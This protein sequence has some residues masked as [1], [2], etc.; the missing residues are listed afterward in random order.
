MRAVGEDLVTRQGQV[1]P[2]SRSMYESSLHHKDHWWR[3]DLKNLDKVRNA[4]DSDADL[5]VKKYGSTEANARSARFNVALPRSPQHQKYAWHNR[6]TGSGPLD[7]QSTPDVTPFAS[8]KLEPAS[9]VSPYAD[10][11]HEDSLTRLTLCQQGAHGGLRF[12]KHTLM[13]WFREMDT[14]DTGIISRRQVV[15]HLRH[16]PEFHMAV[17]GNLEEGDPSEEA[18]VIGSLLQ[19]VEG[20]A[21]GHLEW[22]DFVKFFRGC[23]LLETFEL[24][25]ELAGDGYLVSFVE[26]PQLRNKEASDN[27]HY[28]EALAMEIRHHA[29]PHQE[30]RYRHNRHMGTPVEEGTESCRRSSVQR[31]SLP[32]F[33]EC[34]GHFSLAPVGE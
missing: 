33:E 25:R 16:R 17:F 22:D 32:L 2:S 23:H 18:H 20:D 5:Q 7:C 19:D 31:R 6:P 9:P 8:E 27:S 30:S 15:A 24:N 34:D 14:G 3:P 21:N 29:G 28:S 13:Q 11:Q 4:L 1:T 26:E 12:D 10:I